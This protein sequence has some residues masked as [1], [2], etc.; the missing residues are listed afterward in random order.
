MELSPG[1]HV[2]SSSVG[3]LLGLDN[4]NDTGTV[5]VEVLQGGSPIPLFELGKHTKED[6]NAMMTIYPNAHAVQ[7]K[8]KKAVLTVTQD[9]AKK[10]IVDQNPIPLLENYDK[11]IQAQDE[12]SGLSETNPNLLHRT[13]RRIWAFTENP[14]TDTWGF[15]NTWEGAVFNKGSIRSAL[16]INEFDGERC[17]KQ[18]MQ[19]SNIHG[20]GGSGRRH[21]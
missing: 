12:I 9:D 14:N 3:G 18:D 7:L 10:Y 4:F 16:D 15:T 6:W 1:S 13:T 20:R 19:D 11:M 8:S 5:K 17:M 21:C 2:I